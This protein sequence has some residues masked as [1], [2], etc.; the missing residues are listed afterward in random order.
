MRNNIRAELSKSA[1]IKR[2]KRNKRLIVYGSLLA[3]IFL[4]LVVIY[5]VQSANNN[6]SK[7]LTLEE[8]QEIVDAQLSDVP[9]V[10]M[11][12][13]VYGENGSYVKVDSIVE[14]GTARNI[15]L[16][17][18]Y[19]TRD[20]S[21]LA[22]SLPK[23]FEQAYKYYTDRANDGKNT[24]GLD[25]K[26][27]CIAAVKEDLASA[28]IKT[29]KITVEIFEIT[30]GEF[31]IHRSDEVVNTVFSGILDV[32]DLVDSTNSIK[33]SGDEIDITN[34]ETLRTGVK[35]CFSLKNYD[36]K[37]PDTAIPLIRSWNNF[38]TQFHQDFIFKNRY[39]YYVNG[40]LTTLALTA[41]A[42]VLGIMIGF[43]VA[44][45]RVINQKTGK[46]D[47]AADICK[48][49]LAVMRGMPVMVQI[50]IIHFVF[51]A[52]NGVGKF[53]SAVCCFG[54]NSGAYVSEIIRGGIMSVD[55]GQ[56]EAGRSLG[57]NY[58]QTMV[59]IIIPQAFKAVLP[60]LGNEFIALLKETSIAFY[61]GLGEL[62]LAG[63]RVRSQT[64][65]SFMPLIAV[66]IIYL[67][68]VLGLSYGVSVLERRLSKGD[69]R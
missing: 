36:D 33:V 13:V 49:Y 56:T 8:A 66:G 31:V 47:I 23:Y 3:A 52:P 14:Y 48:V 9:N 22:Q 37:K 25:I 2:Q 38:K 69:K 64:Y 21:V 28:E 1:L 62:T 61:I 67:I 26:L 16:D 44:V 60:S 30:D 42:L 46:L 54:L 32:V 57:F 17:C 43:V 51:M 59:N 55:E 68:V 50:M 65:H 15:V 29:G 40:L 5:F 27:K 34:S 24:T 18:S 53:V 4:A 12:T 6:L 7:V 45:I 35:Y 11:S 20:Y 58:P 63:I 41:C 39:M 10:G 19:T